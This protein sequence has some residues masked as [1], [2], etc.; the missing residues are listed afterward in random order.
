VV[1]ERGQVRGV[2]L[3]RG[4]AM[5]QR[6]ARDLDTV[7]RGAGQTGDDV[8]VRGCGARSS[9]STYSGRPISCQRCEPGS[10][11]LGVQL[12]GRRLTGALSDT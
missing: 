1:R 3:E 8:P 4:D 7:G 2:R 6:L 12:V 5:A 9:S 10:G 11:P